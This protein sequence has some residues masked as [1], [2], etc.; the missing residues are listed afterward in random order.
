MIVE[1][2]LGMMSRKNNIERLVKKNDDSFVKDIHEVSNVDT[3]FHSQLS[4]GQLVL[5][6]ISFFSPWSTAYVNRIISVV[7]MRRKGQISRDINF[8]I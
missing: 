5:I 7:I 6:N 3:T 1:L 2:F 4:T 8:N